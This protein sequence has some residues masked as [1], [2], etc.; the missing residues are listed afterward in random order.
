MKHGIR[1][2]VR[3]CAVLF[4]LA[5]PSAF[6]A[7]AGDTPIPL[8][9]HEGSGLS[10]FGAKLSAKAPEAL[11]VTGRTAQSDRKAS[12]RAATGRLQGPGL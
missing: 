2:L 7:V 4:A 11:A 3:L 12:D 1:L 8:R 10:G 9:T 5:A 6:A